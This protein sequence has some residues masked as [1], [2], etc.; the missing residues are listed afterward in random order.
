MR[1]TKEHIVNGITSYAELEV[2]PQIEDKSTRIIA[3]VAVKAIKANNSLLDSVFSSP[4]LKEILH[5]DA[6]GTYEIGEIFR[7]L[8]ESV[9][10]FGP[11]P[12]IIPPIP[13]ISPDEKLLSF[14]EN[15]VS[16]IKRYIERSN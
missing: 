4:M 13:F 6:N 10:E 12:V 14:N 1:V 2:I 8:E 7:Y 11:F 9:K 5:E 16:N 3:S 15:D